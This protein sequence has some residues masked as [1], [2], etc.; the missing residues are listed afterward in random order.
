MCER[1]RASLCGSAELHGALTRMRCPSKLLS[2][3][4]EMGVGS[5][6]IRMYDACQ[7][8]GLQLPYMMLLK[9]AH[10]AQA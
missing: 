2:G 3:G 10:A 7:G 9:W 1:V 4:G 8:E 5:S 6:S